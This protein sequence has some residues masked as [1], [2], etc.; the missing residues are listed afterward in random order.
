LEDRKLRRTPLYYACWNGHADVMRAL[1]QRGQSMAAADVRAHRGGLHDV[2]CRLGRTPLHLAAWNGHDEATLAL[3]QAG[4]DTTAT[5]TTK[6]LLRLPPH[7]LSVTGPFRPPSPARRR[8]TGSELSQRHMKGW[9]A[10][11]G[12][13]ECGWR[14]VAKHATALGGGA[15]ARE[16]R[17]VAFAVGRRRDGDGPRAGSYGVA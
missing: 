17:D 7:S 2:K 10:W 4:A 12:M 15:R 3:L 16:V 8:W 5:D 9:A 14:A 13:W 1:L 11:M 6:V